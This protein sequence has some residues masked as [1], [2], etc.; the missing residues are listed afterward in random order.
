MPLALLLVFAGGVLGTGSRYGLDVMIPTGDGW[1]WATFIIN[2]AGSFALGLVVEA[3]AQRG[4]DTG[5][6]R[7]LRLFLGPGVLGGFTTYSAFAV[8]VVTRPDVALAAVYGVTSVIIGVFA[9][10]VGIWAAS[11]VFPTERP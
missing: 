9:A 2:I 1:P 6:R 3:I 11:V 7:K 8:E 10:L 4:D 5:R